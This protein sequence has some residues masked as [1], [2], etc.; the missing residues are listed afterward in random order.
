MFLHNLCAK[1]IVLGVIYLQ[2][3][4]IKKQVSVSA[5]CLPCCLVCVQKAVCEVC[6]VFIVIVKVFYFAIDV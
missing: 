6:D 4:G 5:V 3:V 1:H 2:Y